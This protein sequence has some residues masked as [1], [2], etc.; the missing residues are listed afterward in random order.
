MNIRLMSL[1][2]VFLLSAAASAQKEPVLASSGT[3]TTKALM[4]QFLS[5]LMSLRKYMV[6]EKR[7]SD[8]KNTVEI[9]QRLK[10]MSRLSVAAGH[11]PLL[12]IENFKMSREVLTS[13]MAETERVYKT[14]NKDFAR[15]MLNSTVYVC[16]SCHTQLPAM[17]KA[18]LQF[19][20]D[21]SFY[22]EFEQA[23]FLFAARSFQDALRLYDFVIEK[24]SDENFEVERALE[25]VVVYYSRV[26]RDP[27]AAVKKLEKYRLIKKLP[28]T[29]RTQ[30]SDWITQFKM[31]EKMNFKNVPVWSADEVLQLA[32][33]HL[34][35]KDQPYNLVTYAWVSGVLYEYLQGHADSSAAPEILYWLAI[36]DNQMS[37]NVFFSLAHMFLREC[38]VKYP[39]TVSAQKCYKEYEEEM[40]LSYSGTRGTDIPPDVRADLKALKKKAFGK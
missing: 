6:S 1:C 32:Q 2:C 10:E 3:V 40:T 14:G 11:D 36:S 13:H 34:Q 27:K 17:D 8:P 19:K 35:V 5:E 24:G 25:R 39:N 37:N 12:N 30:I 31:F 29:L 15:W 28:Q 23:E 33:K 26:K 7:F 16:M 4:Q 9:S 22:S 20:E 38:I 18:L 21:G